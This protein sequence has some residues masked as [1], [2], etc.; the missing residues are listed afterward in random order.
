[1]LI[2]FMYTVSVIL[3][4]SVGCIAGEYSTKDGK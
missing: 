2:G 4:F 3:A 1:M